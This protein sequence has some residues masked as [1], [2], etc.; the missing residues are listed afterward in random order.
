VGTAKGAAADPNANVTLYYRNPTTSRTVN[1][2]IGPSL[3]ELVARREESFVQ[4]AVE[5]AKDLPRL[6]ELRGTL[7]QRMEKSAL[8]DAGRFAAGIEAAYREAW[9]RWCASAP[10]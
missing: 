2:K 3:P 6:A 10:A 9:R 4:T 8:M 5:L 1:I 7:R